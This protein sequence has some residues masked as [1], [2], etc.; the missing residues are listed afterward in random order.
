MDRNTI[1]IN[2]QA[3]LEKADELEEI[4]RE[5]MRA[6]DREYEESMQRL[7]VNWK[8][9]NAETYLKKGNS[10]GVQMRSTADGV[11]EA[12]EEIRR[13]ARRIYNAEMAAIR[14]IEARIYE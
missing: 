10:L 6:L 11:I 5:L 4:G 7:A 14:I 2:Y 9:V 12:A 1:E 8:G 13:T 3:A